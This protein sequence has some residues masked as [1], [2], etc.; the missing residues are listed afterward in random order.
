VR[1]GSPIDPDRYD[2]TRRIRR[3]Q[4]TRDVMTAIGRLSGQT[5][6][7]RRRWR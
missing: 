4:I 2:G 6:T 3:R 7:T 1:F 5:Y